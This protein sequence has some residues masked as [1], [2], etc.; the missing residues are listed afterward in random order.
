M[1]RANTRPQ[2]RPTEEQ[3]QMYSQD[4][5]VA[6]AEEAHT[7]ILKQSLVITVVKP[8]CHGEGCQSPKYV[9]LCGAGEICCLT[10]SV[11]WPTVRMSHVRVQE[12][13]QEHHTCVLT[14]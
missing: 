3:K 10:P 1:L 2:G 11:C 9:W 8:K 13:V 7:V 12:A 6:L 14:C 5:T 4:Y